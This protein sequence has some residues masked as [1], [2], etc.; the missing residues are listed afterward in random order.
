MA[1][2][3]L[4]LYANFELLQRDHAHIQELSD[5]LIRSI[6]S[7]VENV[8]RNGDV[9]GYPGCVNLSFAYVEGESLLMAL[10]VRFIIINPT[11][12]LISV[13][14]R[15]LHSLQVVRAHQ[16]HWNPLTSCVP[17]VLQRTWLTRR[18]VSVSA[19]SRQKRRSILSSSTS[20]VQ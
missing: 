6:N 7:K 15:T 12:W 10:K 14:C 3:S 2:F 9:N 13:L 8:V 11:F 17:L 20:S 1:C 4:K 16:H 18:S 5:R 19:G